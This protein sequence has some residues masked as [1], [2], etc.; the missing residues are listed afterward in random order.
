MQTKVSSLKNAMQL[1]LELTLVG[2][3]IALTNLGKFLIEQPSSASFNP[4]VD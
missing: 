4:R 1:F 2:I 3:E